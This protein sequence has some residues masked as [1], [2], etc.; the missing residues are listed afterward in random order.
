MEKRQLYRFQKERRLSLLRLEFTI[1]VRTWWPS[2]DAWLTNFLQNEN[3]FFLAR[4]WKD[5]GTFNPS[6]FLAADWPRDAFIP[7]SSGEKWESFFLGMTY[8]FS[9][10]IY[11]GA[12]SCIGRK[13]IFFP[14]QISNQKNSDYLF[15]SLID[16]LRLKP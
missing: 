3:I 11:A 5:P 1:I 14:L 12:R 10:E 15:F 7:F 16:L 2:P 9:S 6:R 8:F 13:Y 4:Y